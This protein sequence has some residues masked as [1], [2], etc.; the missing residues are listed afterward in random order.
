MNRQKIVCGVVL[1][2]TRNQK[3]EIRAALTWLDIKIGEF[4]D[5]LER[6][7]KYGETRRALVEFSEILGVL[8]YLY[9]SETITNEEYKLI[10][11]KIT[12]EV[13]TDEEVAKL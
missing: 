1:S 3:N 5:R 13:L 8:K 2:N 11:K 4:T 7:S 10:I 12:G 6:N 9:M